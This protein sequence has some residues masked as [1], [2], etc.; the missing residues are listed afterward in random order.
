MNNEILSK[1]ETIKALIFDVDG[2][3]TDGKVLVTERGEQW[4]SMSIKDGYA[5]KQAV[6]K[7]L[8]VAIITGGTSEGVAKRLKG[9]GIDDI[10]LGVENKLGAYEKVLAKFDV[11]ASEVLYMGDD[12]PDLAVM[13]QVGL[14]ACPS[15]A[16][17]E[18]LE[19]SHFISSHIGGEGCVREVIEKIMKLQ[20]LWV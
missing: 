10:F 12:I 11:S 9:L 7:G 8:R 18:I 2:V 4:R 20:Q 6:D 17:P 19:Q 16:A 14:A 13:K 3:L 1:F 15:N 5:L